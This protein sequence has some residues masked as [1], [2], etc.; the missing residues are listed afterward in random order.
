MLVSVLGEMEAIRAKSDF[1]G[2]SLEGHTRCSTLSYVAK[3]GTREQRMVAAWTRKA[4]GHLR[5]GQ[6]RPCGLMTSDFELLYLLLKK[7]NLQ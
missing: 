1:T 4:V 7:I 2:G 6:L 5:W 3:K